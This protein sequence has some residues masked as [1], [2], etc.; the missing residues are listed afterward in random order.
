MTG[1]KQWQQWQLEGNIPEAYEEYLVPRLFAPW[2]AKLI[3]AAE[4]EPEEDVL[5]VACGTG[6]VARL[7]AQN[8]EEPGRIVGLDLNPEMLA[9]A[10]SV[11]E[12][13]EPDI[14]WREGDAT[15]L[16]FEDETFDVV[17]CQFSFQYFQDRLLALRE[18]RRV[19]RPGGRLLLNF[20][21]SIEHWPSAA[22]L[23][24]ALERHVG[25]DVAAMMKGPFALTDTE[26]VRSLLDEAGYRDA[27]MM[28]AVE[29]FRFPSPGQFVW[30]QVAGSPLAGPLSQTDGE[31]RAAIV[32][33]VSSS[34][35]S[36]LDDDGLVHPMEAYIAIAYK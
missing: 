25:S 9:V 18:M 1:E 5:D 31:T 27:K 14:E 23:V 4:L 28:I 7:A 26:Q 10:R 34:L 35:Q 12:E 22:S 13:V 19:L 8:V 2:A 30:Q 11:S 29:T 21:R 6:I 33:H 16:P 24:E 3:E 17:S 36:Y 20:A 15:A 32:E